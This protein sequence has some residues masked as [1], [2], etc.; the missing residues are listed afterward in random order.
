VFE[1]AM[2]D[3]KKERERSVKYQN[4]LMSIMVSD[5]WR[6]SQPC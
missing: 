5:C 2:T 4:L 6:K 1:L 3:E